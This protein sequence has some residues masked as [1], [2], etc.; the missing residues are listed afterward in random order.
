M[1]NGCTS[2]AWIRALKEADEPHFNKL[3]N[4]IRKD[5]GNIEAG[6]NDELIVQEVQSSPRAPGTFGHGF[7]L[8]EPRP[9][10]GLRHR[11]RGVHR[12]AHRLRHLPG[13]PA[14]VLLRDERPR[15]RD[16]RHPGVHQ[17]VRERSK[18]VD[19]C[20]AGKGLAPLTSAEAAKVRKAV[21]KKRRKAAQR[22][23][24]AFFHL[25]TVFNLSSCAGLLDHKRSIRRARSACPITAF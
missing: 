3:C 14:S 9:D 19:G 20:R 1:Q 6:E 13:L 25:R 7:L 21:T 11:R 5:G 2:F 24:R 12:Q 18:G 16:S 23:A 22:R 10:P 17:R 4:P 8:G 15:W